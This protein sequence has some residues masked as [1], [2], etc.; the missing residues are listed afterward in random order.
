MYRL[1][2]LAVVA[3][4]ALSLLMAA[5][6][7]SA[8][9]PGPAS[10]PMWWFDYWNLAQLRAQGITGQGITIAVVDT[11]VQAS[12]PELAGKVLSGADFTG[13]GGDGRVDY[14]TDD[15]GHGTAMSSLMVAAPG[16]A[17][18]QGIAPGAMLLP[19]AVPLA[20]LGPSA[21]DALPQAIRW[22]ADHGASIISMSL[23]GDR[24]PARDAVPCPV[25]HQDAITYAISKGAIVVAAS[26]NGGAQGS[27]VEEPGVCLGVVSVGAVD[28]SRSVSAF[29]SRH[30]YLTLSAPGQQIATLSKVPGVAYV[31][32][33]TSQAT[34]ITSA[35]L[36]LV[37]SR[38][39]SLSG[40][41]IV[42]KVLNSAEDLGPAGHDDEYG[43][44]LIRPDLAISETIA[45]DAS[46]PV[47]DGIAPYL[48]TVAASESIAP[49][50]PA[51]T[52][53][54]PPGAVTIGEPPPDVPPLVL[55]GAATTAVGVLLLCLLL[56]LA[57]GA[58]GRRRRREPAFTILPPP[59]PPRS[60][61][62]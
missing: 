11:G 10:A 62:V 4:V 44:G 14:D 50:P 33:G 39:P 53:S 42:T 24:D 46:N 57:V 26:G 56:V 17:G 47:Y 9:A 5:A 22:A 58:R 8:A 28:P 25:T 15:F 55:I 21:A 1:A 60:P 61:P 3:T 19:I 35:A 32:E 27:P 52:A 16:Y 54:A 48:P 38:F 43:Y 34:A 23:G 30:P 45:S 18:I 36:A 37:W 51:A 59:P 49:A 13:H 40:R 2:R 20:G 29:S 12:I 31:G 6:P 7:A 41:E